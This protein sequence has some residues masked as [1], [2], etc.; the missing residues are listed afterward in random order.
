M[1]LL[2]LPIF[3]RDQTPVSAPPALQAE[4]MSTHVL[5]RPRLAEFDSSPVWD[6]GNGYVQH[7]EG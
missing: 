2:V 1:Q 7:R 3:C 4:A 6:G 5:A